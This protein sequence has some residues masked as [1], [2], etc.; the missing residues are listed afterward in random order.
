MCGLTWLWKDSVNL[1]LKL[2]ATESRGSSTFSSPQMLPNFYLKQ[3][4]RLH[5]FGLWQQYI[6]LNNSIM[7]DVHDLTNLIN[8]SFQLSD[9]R[10]Q[11]LKM[12]LLARPICP[13]RFADLLPALLCL[14]LCWL[15]CW[16]G[17]GGARITSEVLFEDWQGRPRVFKD[18][19]EGLW[20]C[21][22]SIMIELVTWLWYICIT[23]RMTP[24]ELCMWFHV[25]WLLIKPF[26]QMF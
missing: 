13:L 25:I 9:A 22:W 12:R 2:T 1:P 23:F 11:W 10:L 3:H 20:G 26:C 5:Q 17:R 8:Y 14:L 16:L 4:N 6:L 15:A 18:V 21:V 7:E 19:L 24:Q